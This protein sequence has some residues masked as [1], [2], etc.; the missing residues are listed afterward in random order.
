[1]DSTPEEVKHDNSFQ[2]R[3]S[4]GKRSHR[5][6]ASLDVEDLVS[7]ISSKL[8]RLNT[9][10]SLD[11]LIAVFVEVLKCKPEEAAFF[12]DSASNDLPTAVSLYL[13]EQSFMNRRRQNNSIA[14]QHLPPTMLDYDSSFRRYRPIVVDI[15]DLPPNWQAVV[16]PIT[17]VILFEHIPTGAKQNQVPP[18]FAD[19]LPEKSSA[20]SDELS[21]SCVVDMDSDCTQNDKASRMEE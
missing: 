8:E 21:S 7:V 14:P 6:N 4:S 11:S 13:E 19:A 3:G 20:S 15:K 10:D 16:C 1:M 2:E 9:S 5:E 17:G 12:L 18:G